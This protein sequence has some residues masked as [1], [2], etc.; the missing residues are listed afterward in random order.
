[1]MEQSVLEIFWYLVVGIAIVFYAVLDGFDLGVGMLHLL[2]KKDVERRI[3][4]N[5]IGPVWDGN[6]VWLVIVAGA[7]FAGFPDVYATLC[8]S[9][10]NLVMILLAGL[11]F[12]AVAIEF[13]SKHESRRWRQSWDIIFSLA[14]FVIAFGV[15][16]T[17]GNIIEGIPLDAEMV[18]RGT[19]AGI[20]RPYPILVGFTAAALF[21]MHGAIFLLM[22]TEGE[23]H[24]KVRRFMKPSLIFLL[25]TYTLTTIATIFYMPHMLETMHNRPYLFLIAATALAALLWVPR[26]VQKKWDGW[27]FICSSV[28]IALLIAVFGVGIYPVMVRS[29]LD[30]QYS[31]TLFNS[32]ASPLTLKVLAIIVAIGVPLVLAYG[33]WIYRIFRGKVKLGPT[34]Y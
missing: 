8:S 33:Y 24:E 4:L 20:F 23:L 29:T 16:L 3:F 30:E 7:L 22:K 15:G 5:A 32:A 31:L 6:E 19:F 17:L 12:R 18:Y 10:Y 27:A 2:V 9:F 21:T 13:R 26:F 11:I 34:S 14:S 28:G 1:M 25:V